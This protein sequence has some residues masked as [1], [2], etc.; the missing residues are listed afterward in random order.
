MTALMGQT[1]AQKE[2]IIK[3]LQ[4]ELDQ[5]TKRRKDIGKTYKNTVKEFELDKKALDN[6]KKQSDRMEKTKQ[7]KENEEL[8]KEDDLDMVPTK[9]KKPVAKKF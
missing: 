4:D 7:R 2:S 5:E 8:K 6:I 3:A 1:L 9:E